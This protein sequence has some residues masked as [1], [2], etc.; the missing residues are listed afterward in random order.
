M[1]CYKFCVSKLQIHKIMSLPYYSLR[2]CM[3][4]DAIGSNSDVYSR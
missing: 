4:G 3:S 1:L 2:C